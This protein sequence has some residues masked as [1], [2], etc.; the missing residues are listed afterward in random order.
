M[1]YDFGATE[2]DEKTLLPVG[3]F[4]VHL[5]DLR[6]QTR[7]EIDAQLRTFALKALHNRLPGLVQ[8]E[9]RYG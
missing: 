8:Y 1:A 2:L 3:P 5:H 7:P 9:A 4:T 6:R